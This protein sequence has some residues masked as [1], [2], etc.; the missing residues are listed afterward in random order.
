LLADNAESGSAPEGAGGSEPAFVNVVIG[1]LTSGGGDEPR[2]R[3]AAWAAVAGLREAVVEF[4][5]VVASQVAADPD[6][7]VETLA[8]GV[9]YVRTFYES[10]LRAAGPDL[11]HDPRMQASLRE[12]ARVLDQIGGVT[13]SA[14][15]RELAGEIRRA[16]PASLAQRPGGRQRKDSEPRRGEEIPLP[17]APAGGNKED[18]DGTDETLFS[19]EG[20]SPKR[21]SVIEDR[22]AAAVE[23]L[24]AAALFAMG[25]WLM[26]CVRPVGSRE[27]DRRHRLYSFGPRSWGTR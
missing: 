11:L 3:Q 15:A 23:P 20:A 24:A 5:V 13:G 17:Q 14:A 27:D 22:D 2:G 21:V 6:G 4:L 1:L 18:R 25:A 8:T 10:A 7:L 16:N 12:A 26:G 9:P 19:P